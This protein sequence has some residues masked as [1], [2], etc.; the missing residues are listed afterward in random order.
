MPL[1][2][3]TTAAEAAVETTPPPLCTNGVVE[4]GEE[5]DDGNVER[6]DGCE[7]CAVQHVHLGAHE[8]KI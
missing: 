5:C 2:V 3:T 8:L 7:G 1:E 6:G 4:A